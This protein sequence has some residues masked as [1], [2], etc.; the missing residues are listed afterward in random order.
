MGRDS[1]LLELEGSLGD[2][3]LIYPGVSIFG[4]ETPGNKFLKVILNVGN[5]CV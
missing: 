3:K 2:P 5:I 1:F 4:F